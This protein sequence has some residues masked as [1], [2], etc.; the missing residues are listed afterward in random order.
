MT[1]ARLLA[2]LADK[3]MVVGL[4]GAG[5]LVARHRAGVPVPAEAREALR[6]HKE[7]IAALLR[8]LERHPRRCPQCGGP[9]LPWY[10]ERGG[11]V[12]CAWCAWTV[13]AHV[14]TDGRGEGAGASA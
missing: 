9:L 10:T 8:R 11:Q 4:D 1:P 13:N 2:R 5:R 3:G 14:R 6:R 7:E 12:G